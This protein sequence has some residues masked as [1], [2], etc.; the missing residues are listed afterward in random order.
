MPSRNLTVTGKEKY[1]LL[2]S[3]CSETLA[4]LRID[5]ANGRWSDQNQRE[6]RWLDNVLLTLHI[7]IYSITKVRLTLGAV[8]PRTCIFYSN[9]LLFVNEFIDWHPLMFHYK[10]SVKHVNPSLTTNH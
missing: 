7:S 5:S 1:L 2:G 9:K 10:D 6:F 3:L 8:F 4:K